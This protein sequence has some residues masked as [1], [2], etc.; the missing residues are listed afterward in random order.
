MQRVQWNISERALSLLRPE[1]TV[2]ITTSPPLPIPPPLATA[3]WTPVPPTRSCPPR[4]ALAEEIRPI[5]ATVAVVSIHVYP[6]GTHLLLV[7][8]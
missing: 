3:P 7:V 4:W 2:A 1:R 8:T 5:A 6:Y